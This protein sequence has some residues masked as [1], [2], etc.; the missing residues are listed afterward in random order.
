MKKI[1]AYIVWII[2][3]VLSLALLT[4]AFTGRLAIATS[5]AFVPDNVAV[6]QQPS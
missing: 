3:L 1:K 2:L 6:I 4:L 5:I